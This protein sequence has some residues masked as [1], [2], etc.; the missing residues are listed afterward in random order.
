VFYVYILYSKVDSNFYIGLTRDLRRRILEHKQGKVTSTKNRLPISLI[1]YEAYI[2]KKD[3][4]RRELY[5]KTSKGKQT[6]RSMLIET[7]N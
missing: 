5:F 6:L 7:L 4:S 1:F 3:A 2:N